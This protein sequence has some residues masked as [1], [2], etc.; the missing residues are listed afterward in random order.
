MPLYRVLLHGS[1]FRIITGKELREVDFFAT[2]WFRAESQ[3]EVEALAIEGIS[4]ELQS[5]VEPGGDPHLFVEEVEAET[6]EAPD[7]TPGFSWFGHD[8]EEAGFEAREGE[9]EAFW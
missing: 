7:S 6:L 1:N 8:N 9:F 5:Q 3:E 4:E 2:R